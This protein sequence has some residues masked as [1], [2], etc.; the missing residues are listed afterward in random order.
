MEKSIAEEQ[1][2]EN[3]TDY[4]TEICREG[5]QRMLAAALETEIAV[6]IE[7]YKEL[8]DKDGHQTVVRNG[9]HRE[10]AIQTG[11]GNIAIRQPR[12]DGGH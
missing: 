12:I 6:F 5:A 11:I 7:K 10:K 9:Y 3:N 1:E 8:K 2:K 4:L